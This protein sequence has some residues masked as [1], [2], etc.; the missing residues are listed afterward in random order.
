MTNYL[1]ERLPKVTDKI[2]P[3]AIE[4]LKYMAYRIDITENEIVL[5]DDDGNLI[6]SI[7]IDRND[8]HFKFINSDT[9]TILYSN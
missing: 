2:F 7:D 3:P 6:I 1:L 8:E 4:W 5:F 9:D